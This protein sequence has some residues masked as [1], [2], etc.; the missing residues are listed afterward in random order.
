[1]V[2][3]VL[4]WY[5]MY[6]RRTAAR[7]IGRTPVVKDI[8]APA[9]TVLNRP[10]PT[11]KPH[12]TP[13]LDANSSKPHPNLANGTVNLDLQSSRRISNAAG[14]VASNPFSDKD[15]IQTAGTEGTNVIPIALVPAASETSESE[16]FSDGPMRPMRSP[17]LN[18]NLD[19]VNVSSD[20]LRPYAQSQRSGMS[21]MS[22][23]QSYTSN[24]SY[25]SDFLNEVPMIVSSRG[26]VRQVL[27]VV[28]AEV[29]HTPGAGTAPSS[30]TSNT[31]K[32]PSKSSRP[33]GSPL[34][35]TSFGPADMVRESNQELE[36]NV[37]GNPF[38]DL[39]SPKSPIE[40][41]STSPPSFN[42]PMNH[43]SHPSLASDWTPDNPHLP[44]ARSSD[45]RPVSTSS[46]AASIA[47]I[48]SATRV[49]LGTASPVTPY[50]TAMGRL[51]SP[52]TGGCTPGALQE[53]QLAI[54]HAQA[55]AQ[56]QGGDRRV[57]GSSVVT[58]ASMGG[59]SILE[60]FPFVPPSPI[61]NRPIRTPPV[62]PLANSFTTE[63]SRDPA[64][65]T[66]SQPTLIPLT[67][68][69]PPNR[70]MLGLSQLS[71]ASSG[72]GSFPFQI[73]PDQTSD[74][75]ASASIPGQV[76]QRASLDTIALT[77]DL[78]SYPLRFDH[79]SFQSGKH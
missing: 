60:S 12:I 68:L 66:R 32:V 15:S 62:S 38:S 3:L 19:H 11:E 2:S 14:S 48:G 45:S 61:S 4:A 20:T 64:T 8:P 69:E 67:P 63:S 1:M 70:Q 16:S 29:I 22:S 58:A 7:E 59:D 40:R 28:K 25:S 43:S 17:E 31:L 34:A 13:Q 77:N 76:R 54:A 52:T 36:L 49:Y 30:P 6:R 41:S 5:F 42:E 79:D 10:D 35:A 78:S 73:E 71:T 74:A 44:W 56:A 72:L 51:V 46:Q 26:A 33:G 24:A 57:S 47:D 23:R 21:G 55:Q 9:E 18:L 50:R 27:G 53:Q 39:N 37:H 75:R 65:P